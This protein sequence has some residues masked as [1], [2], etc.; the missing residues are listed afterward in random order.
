M[1]PDRAVDL[2]I[3]QPCEVPWASMAEAPGGRFCSGCSRTVH[4]TTR[5]STRQIEGLLAAR[6]G[7]LCVRVVRRPD[8]SLKTRDHPVR[9]RGLRSVVVRLL[10]WFVGTASLATAVSCHPSAPDENPTTASPESEANS[11]DSQQTDRETTREQLELL[12]LL[13][14]IEYTTDRPLD[15]SDRS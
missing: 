12:D 11:L 13:G 6:S 7:R 3:Q 15:R 8:G 9:R 2:R 5:L 10:R 4:D 1:Q 14:Y